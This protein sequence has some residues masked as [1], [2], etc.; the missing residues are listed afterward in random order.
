MVRRAHSETVLQKSRE[1]A[2]GTLSRE[3]AKS[4][5]ELAS[6]G[7]DGTTSGLEQL[8]A[9]VGQELAPADPQLAADAGGAELTTG[10]QA[11]DGLDRDLKRSRS[12]G[13][14]QQWFG[15]RSVGPART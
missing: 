12:V 5:S 15:C 11:S 2:C 13:H 4:L 8:A 6:C 3:A 14:G 9:Q 7:Q 10:E 1:I